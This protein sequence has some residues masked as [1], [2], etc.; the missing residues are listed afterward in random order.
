MCNNRPLKSVQNESTNT[1]ISAKYREYDHQQV[2][3]IIKRYQELRSAVEVVSAKYERL[4]GQGD[5]TYKE[6]ILCSL[7]DVDSGMKLLA[8]QQRKVLH[9]LKQG[10]QYEEICSLLDTRLEAV[11]FHARRGFIR[12][13][14]YLNAY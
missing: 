9:M 6:E 10:Y 14:A 13:T 12:L 1:H 4:G 3:G 11:K 5:K 8:P 7:V 2:A